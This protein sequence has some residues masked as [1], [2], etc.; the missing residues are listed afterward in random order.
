M[1]FGMVALDLLAVG[2]VLSLISIVLFIL[3]GI[4]ISLLTVARARHKFRRCA[5]HLERLPGLSGS[6]EL[7]E[8]DAA[9]E[10]IMSEERG[11]LPSRVPGQAIW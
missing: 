5:G 1:S 2:A 8:I 7:A 9:L 6:D 4:A 10:R 11:A 3:F